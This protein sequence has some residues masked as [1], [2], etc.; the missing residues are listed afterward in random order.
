M[1][2]NRRTEKSCIEQILKYLYLLINLF[3]LPIVII[4][5]TN[6][7]L[8]TIGSRKLRNKV[9][10]DISNDLDSYDRVVQEELTGMT[11]ASNQGNEYQPQPNIPIRGRSDIFRRLPFPVKYLNTEEARSIVG[12]SE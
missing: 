4:Y 5:H 7:G 8:K 9:R 12:E 3:N 11:A 10:R 6:H 2:G 1:P